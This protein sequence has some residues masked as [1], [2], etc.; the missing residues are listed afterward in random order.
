M[1]NRLVRFCCTNCPSAFEANPA[2]YLAK[3][4][5]A[6][7]AKQTTAYPFEVGAVSGEKL[8]GHG[9]VINMVVANRLVKLCCEGCI[10]KVN[11]NPAKFIAM[12]DS[13]SLDVKAEE[14]SDEKEHGEQ[15]ESNEHS[16]H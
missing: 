13:G 8:G 6:V 3:L 10:D 14:G 4:D 16:G 9:D 5:E 11:A 7:I 1:N 12:L 15:K 2:K